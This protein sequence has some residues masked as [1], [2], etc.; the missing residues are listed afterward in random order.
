MNVIDAWT[1]WLTF[2]KYKK[3][4]YESNKEVNMNMCVC[5]A[6]SFLI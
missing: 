6:T 5:I 2:I 3:K 1:K 4:Q